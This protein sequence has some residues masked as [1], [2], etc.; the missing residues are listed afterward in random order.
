MG[1]IINTDIGTNY[2]ER[3]YQRSLY[4]V[5]LKAVKDVLGAGAEVTLFNSLNRGLYTEIDSEEPAG[6]REIDR[7]K[8]RMRWYIDADLPIHCRV[9]EKEALQSYLK[10]NRKSVES[11]ELLSGAHGLHGVA[12]Y[13]FE[14]YSNFF[15]GSLMES[16]GGLRL[17]DLVPYMDGLLLRYPHPS[18]PDRLQE[19]PGDYKLYASFREGWTLAELCGLRFVGDLNREIEQGHAG[20]IIALSER[21]HRA[22]TRVIAEKINDK[23]RRVV[24]IAGPSSSGKTT[25]A[26]RLIAQLAEIGP[27]P[28]YLGTDDYFIN[29]ADMHPGPDGKLDFEAVNAIDIELFNRNIMDM[30]EGKDADLPIFDFFEG[31]KVFGKRITSLKEGQPVVIEGLHAL[32]PLLS[33]KLPH[34]DIF[35]IYISPLTQLN[36]DDHNR[37]PTTDI[38]LIRRILRD[39]RTRG[40]SPESTIKSWPNVRGGESIYVFPYCDGADMVF[41]SALLYE[42][43]VLKRHA[44]KPLKDIPADSPEADDAARLLDFLS[45]YRETDAKEEAAIPGD[46][47]LR[48]F[49][50][51]GTLMD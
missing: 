27:E 37:I 19:M 35:K 24:L 28:L 41:N 29:R 44:E 9:L 14:G 36:L 3:S 43:P 10:K 16:T 40:N 42:L 46:S 51:G 6:V 4:L 50:G 21:L 12:V 17:F 7:I 33:D 2:A 31:K 32:N 30:L 45:F 1:G 49:I 23:Q 18:K 48:E 20:E 26:K 47:I 8:D 13:E 22:K 15:Y 25:F 38:R 34:R 11:I 39:V 5:Y